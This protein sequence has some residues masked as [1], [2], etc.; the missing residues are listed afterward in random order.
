MT[1]DPK[2]I[3]LFRKMKFLKSLSEDIFRDT[4]VRPVF[5][6]MGLKD[7]RDYC[8]VDEEGKDCLFVS[9]DSFGQKL[10]YV[11]QTKKGDINKS[12]TATES[13]TVAKTQLTTALDSKIS[14]IVDKQRVS[15]DFAM[16]CAS[17]KINEKA[18]K[19]ICSEL[20]EKRIRFYDCDDLIPLIDE[21]YPELW[22]GIDPQKM[23]YLKN[24]KIHLLKKDDS[25]LFSKGAVITND[26]YEPVSLSFTTF[27]Y[28]KYK[29]KIT[30]I[31]KFEN[32]SPESLIQFKK[33]RL[34]L[35]GEAGSGKSTVLGR[36]A[37]VLCEQ[38]FS[39]DKQLFVP[40]LL[41]AVDIYKNVSTLLNYCQEVTQE[42]SSS[43]KPSFS[44]D[45]LT[46]GRVIVLVDALDELPGEKERKNVL[47]K[48]EEFLGP[49]PNC[50][51]ILTSRDYA[52]LKGLEELVKYEDF[53]LT[54]INLHQAQRI[55]ERLIQGKSLS[56]EAVQETVRRL[57]NV[58][59]IELSPMLVT[60]FVAS[61]DFARKDIPANITELFKKYTE[62]M[63][64]RWDQQKG[65]EQQ[66]QSPMKDFLLQK[67]AY[68]MHQRRSISITKNECID[69]FTSEM[70][71]IGRKKEEI[72]QLINETIYRSGLFRV[73]DEKIEFR[74]LLLQEFFAGRGMPSVESIFQVITD[75]WWQKALIFYFG[76][77]PSD[78]KT[79]ET[80]TTGLVIKSP[81]KQYFA[82]VTVGLSIQ[83]C[84]LVPVAKKI[85]LLKWVIKGFCLVS[86]KL[87]STTK[88][89]EHR[90]PLKEFLMYYF[91]GRDSVACDL[92]EEHYELLLKSLK[93]NDDLKG[94]EEIATFWI[95]VGLIESGNVKEAEK[96][97][98][99]FSPSDDRLLLALH[100]GCFL[101]SN[102]KVATHEHKA[103]TKRMCESIAP[104]IKT[105][106]EKLLDEYT[107]E[108]LEVQQGKLRALT[109][110][111]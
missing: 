53:R 45:D 71:K 51:V 92:L 23:P 50:K 56:K 21:H 29:G 42:I 91:F 5:F 22:L 96:V 15:P 36:I 3:P 44:L 90:L 89:V 6:R 13:Y 99:S 11:V 87:I 77:N 46:Q 97:F 74:H 25:V 76:Q 67:L 70:E 78:S 63:L 48:I 95:I 30:Q 88:S 75:S 37:F 40:I 105:I 43:R 109:N 93:E 59:G 49:Y 27:S 100:L 26:S 20:N 83:A 86:E 80:I 18:R 72:E 111:V 68:E 106:R 17:G 81:L 108:L 38:D 60:V 2:S 4:V 16:L 79:L 7:G 54:A 110:H 1:L 34:M 58:H 24:L 31:P 103:I 98:A 85:D 73:F 82:S 8:G 69:L 66:Y 10:I 107:S 55:V 57:Q 64:G 52:Y 9:P 84:Y 102:L 104:R 39:K 101:H 28:K 62:M 14:L 47:L 19:D 35:L 32:I 33:N 65:L 12:S 94:K 41:R 61:S